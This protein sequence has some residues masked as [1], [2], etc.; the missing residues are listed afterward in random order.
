[1]VICSLKGRD[2]GLLD[3]KVGEKGKLNINIL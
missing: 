2:E 3:M 1:M